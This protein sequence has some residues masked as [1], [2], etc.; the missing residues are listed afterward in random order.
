MNPLAPGV[1]VVGPKIT[2]RTIPGKM[3]SGWIGS[4]LPKPSPNGKQGNVT[5]GSDFGM[6]APNESMGGNSG[7]YRISASPLSRRGDSGSKSGSQGFG[8]VKRP[9]AG[10]SPRGL[11]PGRSKGNFGRI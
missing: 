3:R 9:T 2:S 8:A 11:Q 6:G 1:K 10:K 4:A 7:D 5:S